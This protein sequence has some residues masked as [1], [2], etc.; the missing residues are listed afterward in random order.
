MH[1]STVRH[2]DFKGLQELKDSLEVGLNNLKIP[3]QLGEIDTKDTKGVRRKVESS[4]KDRI[5][6]TKR[7][8]RQSL[9]LLRH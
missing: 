9:V 4:M 1:G 8:I 3:G 2:N 6:T 7:T 5:T